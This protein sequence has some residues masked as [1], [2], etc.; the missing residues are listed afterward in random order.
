[1]SRLEK[2]FITTAKEVAKCSTCSR[3]KVGAVLVKEG[4]IIATGWNGVPSGKEHC[5]DRFKK[6]LKEYK[7][8]VKCGEGHLHPFNKI[9]H[10]FAVANELH[11]EQNLIAFCARNGIDTDDTTL[12]LTTSPCSQCAKLLLAAGIKEVKFIELYDRDT[13][14]VEFLKENGVIL[15]HLEERG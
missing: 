12:Y 10:D 6:E 13:T 9:H 15:H 11:A 2:L 8:A 5:E 14:G 3:V 4:R 1:M 7:E